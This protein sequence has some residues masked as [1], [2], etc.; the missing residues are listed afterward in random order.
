MFTNDES[1]SSDGDISTIQ[2]RFWIQEALL[3]GLKKG[4]AVRLA[5]DIEFLPPPTE[6][7]PA[8]KR[9]PVRVS[10]F[11]AGRDVPLVVREVLA[12]EISFR[13]VR[14]KVEKSAW[15]IRHDFDPQF[16]IQLDELVFEKPV[17]EVEL[18]EHAEFGD[19]TRWVPEPPLKVELEVE[20][21]DFKQAEGQ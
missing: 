10:F 4:G 16:Q 13:V 14:M 6:E 7:E 12:R 1:A 21:F 9:I 11:V 8:Y 17:Y 5:H 15:T 20:A 2:K 18:K 3:D 19:W